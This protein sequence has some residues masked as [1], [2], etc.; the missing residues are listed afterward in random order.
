MAP[1]MP[2]GS[3]ACRE[4][5]WSGVLALA[6]DRALSP[7]S[8]WGEGGRP[9]SGLPARLTSRSLQDYDCRVRAG[10]GDCRVGG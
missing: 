4:L 8:V 5:F 7:G 3:V 6:A 2:S 1:G 9:F 10:A